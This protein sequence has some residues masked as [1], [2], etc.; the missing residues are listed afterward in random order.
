[1][2]VLT[3][4]YERYLHLT[5]TSLFF[6]V[7][8]KVK[9]HKEHESC[10]YESIKNVSFYNNESLRFF[11]RLNSLLMYVKTCHKSN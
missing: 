8:I 10:I 2:H 3:Q 11:F 9:Q 7:Q 6:G 4:A 1:M 5:L